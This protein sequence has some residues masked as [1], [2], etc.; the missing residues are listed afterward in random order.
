MRPRSSCTSTLALALAA[1]TVATVAAPSVGFAAE[2]AKKVSKIA[3]GK[4]AITVS[5]VTKGAR[6]FVD[7]KEVGEVPL[8]EPIVVD[9]NQRHTVRV[10]KRGYTPFI[11]TV[12]PS[13]GQ[14]VE[15]EADLVATGGFLQV[16]SKDAALKLQIL[17]DGQIAGTTPLDGDVAPGKHAVEARAAGYLPETQMIDVKAGQLSALEFGLKLVPAP[18]VKEDKSLLSRWWF[19]TAVGTA[20]VGGVVTGV[21]AS[22]DTISRPKAPDHVLVFQ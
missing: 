6:V 12:L 16:K 14:T 22:Q 5:S 11:E 15:L 1:L 21:V 9:A 8:A 10:Q 7:D 20:V 3:D 2:K 17:I 19:W 4:A 18:I 13:N